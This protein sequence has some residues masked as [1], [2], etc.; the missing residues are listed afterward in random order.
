[1]TTAAARTTTEGSQPAN[2]PTTRRRYD[3]LADWYDAEM[4]RLPLTATA[5]TTVAG[6]P[7]PGRGRRL[8]LACG[9]GILLPGLTALGW[10]VTGVDIS[11]ADHLRLAD[12][13]NAFLGA[14][15]TL[16]RLEEPGEDDYPFLMALVLER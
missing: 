15:L 5:T 2:G 12:L 7:G 14:G 4:R 10:R 11:G 16:R 8:D 13:V 3:G 9:T 1:M 6:L